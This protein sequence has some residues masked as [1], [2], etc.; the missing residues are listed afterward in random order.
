MNYLLDSMTGKE[1]KSKL[2]LTGMTMKDIA[3]VLG[4]SEQNLQN[5]M[6]S[7]DIKV[8]FLCK[9]SKAI[10]K[11]VYYLLEG[12]DYYNDVENVTNAIESNIYRE[13]YKEKDKEFGLLKEEIGALKNEIERLNTEKFQET[14]AQNA[15]TDKSSIR[16]QSPATSVD[17]RSRKIE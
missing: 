6:S 8:S 12:Q 16:K 11:S 5:K 1:L 14:N 10:H 15:S 3:E 4:I 13:M 17:V 2:E 7:A 9:V